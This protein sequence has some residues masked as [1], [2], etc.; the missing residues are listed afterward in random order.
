MLALRVKCAMYKLSGPGQVQ[1]TWVTKVQLAYVSASQIED[2]KPERFSRTYHL[3]NVL[4]RE[5]NVF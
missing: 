3:S 4:C 1:L 2:V 5:T